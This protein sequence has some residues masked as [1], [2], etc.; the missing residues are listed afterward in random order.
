MLS[1]LVARFE[2]LE[3]EGQNEEA[4]ASAIGK[5]YWEGYRAA[6]RE[7]ILYTNLE[8]RHPTGGEQKCDY[9]EHCWK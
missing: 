6:M 1:D 8:I 2:T 7:A 9:C 3:K 5:L 4:M